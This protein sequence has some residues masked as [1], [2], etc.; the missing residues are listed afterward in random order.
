MSKHGISI[1]FTDNCIHLLSGPWPLIPM[2]GPKHSLTA[3]QEKLS[4]YHVVLAEP[5]VFTANQR[6]MIVLGKIVEPSS[7][8]HVVGA[9]HLLVEPEQQ[10]LTKYNILPANALLNGDAE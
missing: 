8:R 4:V 2:A 10:L 7:G 9:K 5:V 6:E 1:C 3:S